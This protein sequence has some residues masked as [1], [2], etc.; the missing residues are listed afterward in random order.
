[1]SRIF[2]ILIVVLLGFMAIASGFQSLSTYSNRFLDAVKEYPTNGSF[3]SLQG[4]QEE[5]DIFVEAK[6]YEYADKYGA[7]ITRRDTIFSPTKNASEGYRFGIYGNVDKQPEN[8][9]LEFNG[10]SILNSNKLSHLLNSDPESTLGLDQN[11][12]NMLEDI[13][14]LRYSSKIVAVQLP[15]MIKDSGTLRGDYKIVGLSPEEFSTFLSEISTLSSVEKELL[16]NP[17]GGSSTEYSILDIF[18]LVTLWIS[19]I[20]IAIAAFLA[21]FLGIRQY[22]IYALLGWSK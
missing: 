19:V 4:I 2:R 12:A 16:L 6:L 20:F 3:F 18:A 10:L 15:Q 14:Y 13:P 1:M 17:L 7:A 21:I 22:G 11:S 5:N 8:L 9:L